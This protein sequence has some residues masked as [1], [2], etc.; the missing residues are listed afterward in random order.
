MTKPLMIEQIEF[1]LSELADVERELQRIQTAPIEAHKHLYDEPAARTL[2]R[3]QSMA[4]H[5]QV[6]LSLAVKNLRD[7]LPDPGKPIP[8]AFA[9]SNNSDAPA[10]QSGI[11]P[12]GEI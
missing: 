9:A 7:C 10:A 2:G 12:K 6:I 11:N 8:A 3:C 4:D 1:A 5:A